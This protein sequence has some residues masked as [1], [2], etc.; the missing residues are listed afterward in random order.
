MTAIAIASRGEPGPRAN[1]N[2][3]NPP[4]PERELPH[5]LGNPSMADELHRPG[6]IPRG[7]ESRPWPA[8]AHSPHSALIQSLQSLRERVLERL[9][10]LETLARGRSASAPAAGAS[11][12]PERN[13]EL[14]LAELADTERKLHDES[15]HQEKKWSASLN[16]LESD[17]RLLAEAWERVERERIAYSS[18]SETHHH[19]RAQGQGVEEGA[20]A[21]L[22]HAGA[23]VTARS[24][25]A[26]SD[27]NH[28]ITQAILRQFQTLSSDVRRNAEEHRDSR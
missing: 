20:P 16:Q 2:T 1:Q 6:S 24:A 3:G 12:G 5:S 8:L 4:R 25:A 19:S 22:P 9:D 7:A 17:R 21:A 14:K 26:G 18:A 11:A 13:F 28:P 10:S 27:S 23:L 15:E